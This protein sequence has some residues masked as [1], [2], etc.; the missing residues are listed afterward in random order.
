MIAP[1]CGNGM[2]MALHAARLA[3]PLATRFLRGG[4]SREMMEQV[5]ESHWRAQFARRLQTGRIIQSLFGNEW[6]TN[7]SV[8]LL[9]HFPGVMNRIIRQTH[10]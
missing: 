6:M 3:A 4:M 2:S 5:Y 10:G 9:G 8:R 7:F 1:L